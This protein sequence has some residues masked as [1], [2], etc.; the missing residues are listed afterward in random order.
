MG[1][2]TARDCSSVPAQKIHAGLNH[3]FASHS[4]T[5][6]ASGSV[7]IAMIALPAGARV[8]DVEL[9]INNNAAG[10]VVS[11]G[12]VQIIDGLGNVYIQSASANKAFHQWNPTY[13]SFGKRLTA[14]TN[15]MVQLISMPGSGTA[16]TVFQVSCSYLAD[17]DGD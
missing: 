14:S 10:I 4:L 3:R 6:T 11:A 16:S 2:F 15:L 1:H 13:G 9:Y 5:E 12:E 8:K 7:T 17:L